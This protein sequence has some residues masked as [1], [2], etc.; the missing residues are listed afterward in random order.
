MKHISSASEIPI[1]PDTTYVVD[2]DGVLLANDGFISKPFNNETVTWF[3]TLTQAV[4]VKNVYILTARAESTRKLTLMSLNNHGFYPPS[5]QVFFDRQKGHWIARYRSLFNH[6][7]IIMVDDQYYNIMS[8]KK[9][10][11]DVECYHVNVQLINDQ[12]IVYDLSQ[13]ILNP[14][15]VYVVDIDCFLKANYLALCDCVQDFDLGLKKWLTNLGNEVKIRLYSK[16]SDFNPNTLLEQE[17]TS[18]IPTTKNLILI[19][20]NPTS[21]LELYY[22]YPHMKFIILLGSS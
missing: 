13:V 10:N 1:L 19:S 22:R 11:P 5:E 15:Y 21:C 18:Y 14:D 17:V 7:N 12:S 9:H 16:M 3:K 4:G 8:V 6:P 2:I 20:K